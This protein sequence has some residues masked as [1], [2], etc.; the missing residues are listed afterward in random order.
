MSKLQNPSNKYFVPSVAQYYSHLGLT[1]NMIYI[2]PTEK[3]YVLE[4][5]RDIDTSKAASIDRLPGGFLKDGANA[6]LNWL[7]IFEIFQYL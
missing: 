5:F 2:L 4:A 6:L 1:K 7:Q 3:Y